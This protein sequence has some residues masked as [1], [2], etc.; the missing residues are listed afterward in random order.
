MNLSFIIKKRIFNW[1]QRYSDSIVCNSESAKRM[2]LKYHPEYKTKINVIYN[3]VSIDKIVSNY[4]PLKDGKLHLLVAA[5]YQKLKNPINVVKAVNLLSDEDRS[6]LRIDWYGRKNIDINN[7]DKVYLEAKRIIMDN[8]LSEVI[9]LYDATSDILNKM[10][11]T[12]IIGLFSDSEGLPNA[13]CEAMT[14]G[15]PI[16]MTP[17]SDYT[18]FVDNSNGVICEETDFKSIYRELKEI[19]S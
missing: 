15:K 11:E 6:K 1:F 14:I 19:L 7:L 3:T 2:W 10:N 4:V 16:I 17:V 9:N 5:S 13:I 8:N 12:D 18:N